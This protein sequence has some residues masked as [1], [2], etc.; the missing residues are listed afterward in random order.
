LESRAITAGWESIPLCA[1]LPAPENC[2][3]YP[4]LA[5]KS[6]QYFTK[7]TTSAGVPP[8]FPDFL[9]RRINLPL[10]PWSRQIKVPLFP[11]NLNHSIF[12]VHSLIS[13]ILR[14][15][16]VNPRRA[17]NSCIHNQRNQRTIVTRSPRRGASKCARDWRG[18]QILRICFWS[19]LRKL[20]DWYTRSPGKPGFLRSK[21][22]AQMSM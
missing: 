21:K 12:A 18:S 4:N 19:L 16:P 20:H 22:C 14:R 7:R 5:F 13:P 15:Y 2:C 1:M 3:P 9:S 17:Q 11:D 10:A 6:C 8:L